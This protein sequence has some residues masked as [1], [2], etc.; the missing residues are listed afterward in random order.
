MFQKALAERKQVGAGRWR[1]LLAYLALGSTIFFLLAAIFTLTQRQATDGIRINVVG[2]QRML[3]ERMAKELLLWRQQQL[4]LEQLQRTVQLFDQ[5]MR[6][7][8]EG[9]LVTLDLKGADLREIPP[10]EHFLARSREL[11]VLGRWREIQR[12]LET[13][14][15]SGL[16][17][18]RLQAN[19]WELP[20]LEEIDGV[21]GAIQGDIA[22]SSRWSKGLLALIALLVMG[23][24]LQGLVLLARELKSARKRLLELERLLPICS[25]CKSIR[26]DD[27][28]PM[29][30]DAWT[31][32]EAYLGEQSDQGLTHGLCPTCAQE[33]YKD[34]LI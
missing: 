25:H 14:M 7:L 13:S 19:D 15:R 17:S 33:L 26:V 27:A 34:Y 1:S 6:V 4:D 28:H 10:D 30:P 12:E 5:N 2:R 23:A 11:S 29:E 31:P 22:Q 9:G 8:A 18:P 20:L 3:I 32:I 21:V 24:L 16:L